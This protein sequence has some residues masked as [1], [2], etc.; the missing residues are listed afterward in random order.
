[1]SG[2]RI[3]RARGLT[4]GFGLA[5]I[6]MLVWVGEARA[7]KYAVAQCGW[8]IGSDA[9]WADTT[10]GAKF[11][12]SSY[13]A[14]PP[15][16]DPFDGVHLKSFTRE[17]EQTVSGNRFARWRWTTPP[18]TGIV[19][20]RGTWWHALHDGFEHR[21]GTDS[22][23][24][25]FAPFAWTAATDVGMR[26]FAAGFSPPQWAFEDRLL[27]TRAESKFCSLA[28]SWSGLRA[29]TIT[30]EDD[31]APGGSIGGDL[32]G[33]GWLRG[34]RSIVVW[35]SDIGGGIRFSETYVDGSRVAL[36]EYPC[37][38]AMIGGEWRGTRLLPCDTAV[39]VE[40]WV[41]TTG[42]SDGPHFLRHCLIDFAGNVGCPSGKTIRIDNN[43]PAHPRSAGLEGGEGW[44]RVN[45]FDVR[46]VN[47]GQGV[48]SPIG[49]AFWRV[50]G[51]A[52]FDSGVSFAPGRGVS[53]I[54]NRSVPGPGQYTLQLWL[55]DE[56][57]NDAAATAVEVPLRFDDVAPG[58]AFADG[59]GGGF[60]EQIGA[61][62][63]DEHSGPDV[64][65]LRYRRLGSDSWVALP[66]KVE[67]PGPD[68]ARLVARL[69]EGLAPGTYLFQAEA[70]D[71]AGNRTVTTR[72]ADGTEMALRKPPPPATAPVGESGKPSHG[73]QGGARR[74]REKTRIFARL[75]WRRRSGT[76][77]TVPYGERATLSGRLLDASGAGLA[78]RR[79]RVVSRPSRGAFAGRSV[80]VLE[81]GRRGAFSLRLPAGT[82][83]RIAVGFRGDSWARRSL[84]APL[85]LRV[86]SGVTLHAAPL[87]LETGQ[88][89]RL[90][91]RV[92]TRGAPLPRRGKLVAVQYLESAT[93]R[94]RPVL[95]TRSDH[96]GRFSAEYRFRYVVGTARVRL[97][98]VAL[99]EERWPYAPGG[100]QPVTVRVEG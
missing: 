78:G 71:G 1:M 42:I 15:G 84:R 75:R 65:E 92:H 33:D 38:K 94:W 11:R 48:A 45:D 32:T 60:P 41:A 13:C 4:V 72:R 27:C 19:N 82:S 7:A 2:S 99:A 88:A 43:A 89:V 52:G 66:T 86:R 23:D 51:R 79:V 58:L 93:G 83:R 57:G 64:G 62:A 40:Q 73:A 5:L 25:G 6:A 87:S 10:G 90:R 77:V 26:D 35:G 14:T 63:F 97:R 76:A 24:G 67:R 96:D 50:T 68:R 36:H 44:R 8:G 98:A 30:I 9:V 39:A 91:G 100:S 81:T 47:P 31:G 37:A 61:D 46:W 70:V 21:L 3:R 34:S 12:P 55:R 80:R 95:V 54:P 20:V 16:A 22:G 49:G 17:S 69:P 59:G 29:L 28:G 53:T 18:G 56:A 85:S 74:R